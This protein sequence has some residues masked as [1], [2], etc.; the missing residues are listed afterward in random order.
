M[1]RTIPASI[2]ALLSLA[3]VTL[4]PGARAATPTPIHFTAT[5]SPAPVHAGE[6]ATVTVKAAV[7]P[8]WHVYSVVP[9]AD[10]PA[11]T[12]ILSLT[13]TASA[14]PT[15]EDAVIRKF[16]ANFGRE[17]GFHEN[18]ATFQ[19]QFRVGAAPIAA[20]SVTLHYQTCNDKVCLPPTDVT[21]PVALTVAAG[22]VR[23]EY[24]QA[25]VIAAPPA[26]PAAMAR[27]KTA[28]TGLG[29]FLL[30]ALGA[31]LLA[32]ITP[33]VFP[34]IPITLTNFVKQADGDKGR[35]VRLSAGYALGIVALYVAL[36]A[37]VTATVGATGI[38]KIAANP[39][40]NLGI[41][42]V[43]V[44]F[45]LSFFETIQLTL[46]A[47]LG[48]LQTT[49]RKHGGI[50][51]LALL[52]ITFVLASF[53]C[54]APFLGTLLVAAAGGER[55][56]PLLGMLVFALAFVSPFLVFAA[57]PQWIGKI[58]K[59]GVWLARVKATLGFVELAAALKFLSNADQVWQWKLLTEPVLLAAWSLIFV[60]AALYLWGTLRFGIVAETEPHGAKVPVARGAFALL[61]LVLA[62]YCFRGLAGR[63][64]ALF[65]A[66]LPP[67][68]YGLASG[69]ASEDGLTWLTD[70]NV[71]LAQAKAEGKPL[72]IDF[73]G[74]T[75]TNCRWNEKN[76]FP[77]EDVRRELGNYV[78]VQLYTDRPGDAANQKL[79]LTKFGDVALPLY[80]VVDPQTGNVVDKTAGTITDAGAFTT[81]LSHSRTASSST[82]AAAPATV[83]ANAPAWAPYT[84]EAAS[85][86]AQAGKPTIVDFTAAWCVNCK[87]IEHDVFEHPEV[88]PVLGRS[89]TTLR[90]DLTKWNDPANVALQKQYGFGSLPTIVFLDSSGKEIKN[91]RITGR[92][93]VAE[94]QKRMQAAAPAAVARG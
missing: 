28:N 1:R 25:K 7:D 51:G 3:G 54:T 49:A 55:F 38:N 19:R 67:S 69:G 94:F 32:L 2:L 91:L 78:R 90:A 74:V 57:F 41:F 80:G 9:A 8:G 56:R 65:S 71:A 83:A 18:T 34:L 92:L 60:S 81:F 22:P 23:P 53:T 21:L 93:S 26:A 35:L 36:G 12:D 63:P 45:A 84:P 6:V 37:I 33:C 15:T 43:F 48:A 27:A 75:C 87:E 59:S 77:R 76:V 46:P 29:L 4:A 14:G 89:F 44:V 62:G 50:T 16:D 47:N 66:F 24:A 70:Y 64:V 72:F 86:A 85:A 61:F 82:A 79:Q 88:A 11:V 39:W 40:V 52:G 73:T 42:V 68:G 20:P 31:G 30:A 17:V 58:P 5:V 10:G 13:G